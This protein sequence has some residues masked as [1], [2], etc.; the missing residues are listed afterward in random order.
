MPPSDIRKKSKKRVTNGRL[1]NQLVRFQIIAEDTPNGRYNLPTML[2]V[3]ILPSKEK[4]SKKAIAYAK[5]K[6]IKKLGNSI[7][8]QSRNLLNRNPS[9]NQNSLYQRQKEKENLINYGY[10]RLTG[11]ITE[12]EYWNIE[13]T[14]E[15]KKDRNLFRFKNAFGS[16]PLKNTLKNI[17][18]Y[19]K[20]D[21][22]YNR[23][24]LIPKKPQT[25]PIKLQ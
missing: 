14:F 7:R 3:K 16:F 6:L 5:E 20:V 23:F 17:M 19:K 15:S 12:N 10:Y 9:N 11:N 24:L 22:S 18:N 21:P 1:R 13:R 25:G 8:E 4:L 2:A